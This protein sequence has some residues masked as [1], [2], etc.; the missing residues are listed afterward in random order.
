M[1]H[2]V[3]ISFREDG[4]N[5]GP[6]NSHLRIIES[7]LKETYEF[8]PLVIPKGKLGIIN[9]KLTIKI[10]RQIIK[11]KPEI[12]HFTGLELVG[13]HV[14]FACWILGLKKTIVA[15]HGSS[16]ESR[17]INNNFL[18]RNI[19]NFAE[20]L[21]LRFAGYSYGVSDYTNTINVV[22]SHAKK[23][24]GTIYNIITTKCNNLDFNLKHEYNINEKKIIVISVGRI[25]REKGFDIIT[26]IVKKTCNKNIVFM[27]IGDGSYLNDMKHLLADEVNS[28][29]IIFTG[30]KDNPADYMVQSDIFL[31]PSL[32]E[33]FCM[34]LA[35]AGKSGC[36][37]IANNVGGMKEIINNNQ[38]G[39]LIEGNDKEKYVNLLDYLENNRNILKEMKLKSKS[40]IESKF[41]EKTAIENISN[42]YKIIIKSN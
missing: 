9:P 29:K 27:V 26:E 35:E 16:S 24:L 36:A 17:E 34:A 42:A 22:R 14:G 8:V 2:K 23:H 28:K 11:E 18:K 5:G 19:L 31:M 1:K 39:Y 3:L 21:T 6:Y 7:K 40:Y 41:S 25:E 15:I 33:T 13:F 32:H 38:S 20:K 30:F 12:V 4:A 37:L 10:I